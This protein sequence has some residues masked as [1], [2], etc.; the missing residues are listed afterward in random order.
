MDTTLCTDEIDDVHSP[1]FSDDAGS[2]GEWDPHQATSSRPAA[3]VA[4]PRELSSQITESPRTAMAD[5]QGSYCDDAPSMSQTGPPAHPGHGTLPLPMPNSASPLQQQLGQQHPSQQGANDQGHSQQHQLPAPCTTADRQS[6]APLLQSQ[7][8]Q[9]SQPPPGRKLPS[10][11]PP[12]ATAV[13][14]LQPQ[15][16]TNCTQS[17]SATCSDR[18]ADHSHST[19]TTT[20]NMPPEHLSD[21]ITITLPQEHQQA[22]D[23]P[24]S[25]GRVQE[26]VSGGV[27][28][29]ASR[30]QADQGPRDGEAPPEAQLQEVSGAP[31]SR[32]QPQ[33]L[34]QVQPPQDVSQS[35]A[36]EQAPPLSHAHHP[37]PQQQPSH[38]PNPGVF[39]DEDDPTWSPDSPTPTLHY[40]PG[41]IAQCD[42]RTELGDTELQSAQVSGQPPGQQ[43]GQ[44]GGLPGGQQEDDQGG[45][46]A[47]RP[48]LLLPV[49][50]EDRL[51]KESAVNLLYMGSP[52]WRPDLEAV[53]VWQAQVWRL[54][55]LISTLAARLLCRGQQGFPSLA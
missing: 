27:S 32:S 29:A 34:P 24:H 26:G 20:S 9:S 1:Q 49:S 2:Q 42:G 17:S 38:V 13:P 16:A 12:A 36:H 39:G 52:A 11:A 14:L 7:A 44:Q 6:T 55:M 18:P 5:T 40:S 19:G 51:R 3:A 33:A 25:R 22:S 15:A 48:L 43:G 46:Q 4:S 47:A 30:A 21:S 28:Q 37:M 41:P 23:A 53:H 50:I 10:A 45:G 8:E 35:A 31:L 54:L